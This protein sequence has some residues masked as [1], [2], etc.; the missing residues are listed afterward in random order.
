M[1]RARKRHVQQELFPSHGGKRKGAG[2]PPKGERSSEPHKKRAVVK[3][4][5]PVHV[6]VRVVD[7]LAAL[8]QRE[9]YRAIRRAMLTVF[10][11]DVFHIVAVSIQGS[12]VHLLV[13]AQDRM[14]LARGMQALQISAAKHLNRA[15]S[16]RRKERRRGRVF[17]DRYHAE[18]ITNRRQARHALAYVLNNWRRHGAHRVKELRGFAIDPFSSAIAFDGWRE[19]VEVDWPLTYEPLPVWRPRTWL[20]TTGWR[21]YGLIGT[22][23]VPGPRRKARAA[24]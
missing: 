23:E 19:A 5:E 22:S 10:D 14:A 7:E 13:E 16:K 6:T 18:S 9:S 20:L 4:S 1:G 8:R 12:H 11:R 21:M 24:A 17:G 15:F 2:R 3:K